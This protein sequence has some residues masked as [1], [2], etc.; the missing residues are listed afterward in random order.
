VKR[1]ATFVRC[2]NL[3]GSEVEPLPAIHLDDS[4][5]HCLALDAS[6][7]RACLANVNGEGSESHGLFIV[8]TDGTGKTGLSDS[9]P[10]CVALVT[11][12]EKLY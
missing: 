2:A 9:Y 4:D 6:K 5:V 10:L 3:D 8:G 11:V 1:R 7:S 12:D